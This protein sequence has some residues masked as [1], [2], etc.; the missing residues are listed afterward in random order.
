MRR[1]ASVVAEVL[2]SLIRLG[3]KMTKQESLL[4][5]LNLKKRLHDQLIIFSWFADHPELQQPFIPVSVT[6]SCTSLAEVAAIVEEL[7]GEWE[8]ELL[9]DCFR[10][11]QRCGEIWLNIVISW[12]YVSR[13][14][15]AEWIRERKRK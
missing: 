4:N 6:V 7:E 2:F 11:S 1:I 10:M 12:T 8:K 13:K 5:L 9:P 15:A 3:W 14:E